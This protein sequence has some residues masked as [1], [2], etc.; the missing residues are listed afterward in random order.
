MRVLRVGS[1]YVLLGLILFWLLFP[2]YVMLITSLKSAGE[3]FTI[4][5]T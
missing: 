1:I 4:P 3:I 2:F 5:P